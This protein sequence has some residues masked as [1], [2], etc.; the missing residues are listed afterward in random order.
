MINA[1]MRQ[2]GVSD[3]KGL[4]S[5]V[6]VFQS[7]YESC[8][9]E[10]IDGDKEGKSQDGRKLVN[11]RWTCANPDEYLFWDGWSLGQVAGAV[12]ARGVRELIKGPEGVKKD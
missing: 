6:S 10:A 11:G 3:G 2:Q 7:V 12:F 8:V 1:H 5:N 4:G 9:K